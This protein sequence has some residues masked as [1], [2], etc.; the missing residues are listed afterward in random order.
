MRGGGEGE[1]FGLVAAC[2]WG[3]RHTLSLEET[4]SWMNVCAERLRRACYVNAEEGVGEDIAQAWTNEM[5]GVKW[6]W[7]QGGLDMQCEEVLR[8]VRVWLGEFDCLWL[9]QR[10]RH[11][12]K[13][14]PAASALRRLAGDLGVPLYDFGDDSGPDWD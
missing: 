8:D 7:A 14:G 10:P 6:T 1:A 13:V 2:E 11:K 9:Q 5:G 3:G 4:E 12:I